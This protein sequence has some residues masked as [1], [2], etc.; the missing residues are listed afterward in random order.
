MGAERSDALDAQKNTGPT[1]PAARMMFSEE[2]LGFG[3]CADWV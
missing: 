2:E 1:V 3:F